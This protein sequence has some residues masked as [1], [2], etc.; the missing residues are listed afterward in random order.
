MQT[1]VFPRLGWL[2]V[3]VVTLSACREKASSG[4]PTAEAPAETGPRLYVLGSS[5]HLRKAP[6]PEGESLEKLR[7]GTECV[8]LDPSPGEWRKVREEKPSLE[9]LNGR[10]RQLR[11]D[12]CLP[13]PVQV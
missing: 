6:S 2:L 10:C 1:S 4:Q 13:R 7:I 8:L 11:A 3:V 9:K 5:I 12:R